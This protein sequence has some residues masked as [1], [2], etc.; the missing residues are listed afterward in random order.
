MS[1]SDLARLNDFRRLDQ[2]ELWGERVMVATIPEIPVK[3]R[4]ADGI[5]LVMI[6][7]MERE[8]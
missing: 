3:E 8:A 5:Q 4:T 1:R 7:A 6:D 2:L